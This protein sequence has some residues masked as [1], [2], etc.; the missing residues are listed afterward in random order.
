MKA[1]SGG[2]GLN[3]AAFEAAMKNPKLAKLFEKFGKMET[4]IPDAQP[5]APGGDG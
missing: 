5:S 2:G 1:F 3:P 4:D